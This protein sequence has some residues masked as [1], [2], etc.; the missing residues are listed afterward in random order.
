MRIVIQELKA[1]KTAITDGNAENGF[2]V[3][4][5]SV[6]KLRIGTTAAGAAR[7]PKRTASPCV[8]ARTSS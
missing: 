1:Q 6:E 4:N 5:Q 2:A 3:L 8:R 7:H